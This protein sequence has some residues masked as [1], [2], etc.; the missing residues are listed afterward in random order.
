MRPF[1]ASGPPRPDPLRKCPGCRSLLRHRYPPAPDGPCG[2][3]PP[4]IRGRRPWSGYRYGAGR[5]TRAT[6][7]DNT[8]RPSGE[9]GSPW[10]DA[11]SRQ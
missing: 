7:G 5:Y 8:S 10:D 3:E 4:Q 9:P 11:R 2:T 1:P 6:Y